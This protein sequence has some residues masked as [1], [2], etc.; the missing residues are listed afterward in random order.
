MIH[1]HTWGSP[2]YLI[3][4][5]RACFADSLPY[6]VVGFRVR[7]A[8]CGKVKTVWTGKEEPE[9]EEV[10]SQPKP[11]VADRID[12]TERLKRELANQ[13]RALERKNKA[14]DALHYVWCSGGCVTGVHRYDGK[15][16]EGIT[17]EIVAL[18][19]R[20]TKR[21]RTWWENYKIKEIR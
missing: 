15:G 16:P 10:E 6:I 5:I 19:E 4:R 11:M 9:A 2:L 14:L 21:L 17:E 1:S 13:H 3:K 12:K 18:A 8:E 20:N 7:C